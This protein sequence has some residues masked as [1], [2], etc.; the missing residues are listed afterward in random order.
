VDPY[1]PLPAVR[2]HVETVEALR[3]LGRGE[4]DV[5]TAYQRLRDAVA[6]YLWAGASERHGRIVGVLVAEAA[7]PPPW[8][9]AEAL[10]KLARDWESLRDAPASALAVGRAVWQLNGSLLLMNLGDEHLAEGFSRLFD[11]KLASLFPP[12]DHLPSFRE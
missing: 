1:P 6:G 9:T 3:Q 11:E 5:E 4:V 12:P 10:A 8:W 7:V 2:S